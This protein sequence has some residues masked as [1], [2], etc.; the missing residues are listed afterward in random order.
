MRRQHIPA[1][2][3]GLLIFEFDDGVIETYDI[4]NTTV[5]SS[6]R[7]SNTH[8]SDHDT[9]SV[10]FGSARHQRLGEVT[11]SSDLGLLAVP[12]SGKRIFHRRV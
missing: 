5:S 6:S 2:A 10:Q 12:F 3:Q 7:I 11:F 8:R 1:Q 9:F 4:A